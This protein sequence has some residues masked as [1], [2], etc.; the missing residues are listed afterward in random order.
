MKIPIA[1]T[2]DSP[3]FLHMPLEHDP[4]PDDLWKLD[5]AILNGANSVPSISV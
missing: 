5:V 2:S 1:A 3:S 4:E